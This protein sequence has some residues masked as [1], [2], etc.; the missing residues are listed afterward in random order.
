MGENVALEESVALAAKYG[1][2]YVKLDVTQFDDENVVEIQQMLRDAR[3]RC[4]PMSLPMALY[5]KFEAVEEKKFD[6]QL[7]TLDSHAKMAAKLG[8]RAFI[9]PIVPGSSVMNYEDNMALHISRFQRVV[10]VLKLHGIQLGLEY[11][12]PASFRAKFKYPFVASLKELCSMI[13]QIEDTMGS[14]GGGKKKAEQVSVG[15]L[16]DTFHWKTVGESIKD[17]Q[18]LSADRIID[19]QLNDAA[20]G[21]DVANPSS[22]DA[23]ARAMPGATGVIDCH[24]FLS[25]LE[26]IRYSGSVCIEPFSRD[27]EALSINDAC[28]AAADIFKQYLK[29]KP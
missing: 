8:C 23:Q 13:D 4:A 26:S 7:Q 18:R 19:V 27:I 3:L 14:N 29:S 25:A 22:W 16:L 1:F 21:S 5:D 9:T 20:I 12:G 2:Q 6:S 15:I 28:A 24:A 11:I 17:I 10:S